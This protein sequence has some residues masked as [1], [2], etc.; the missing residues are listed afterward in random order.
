MYRE[1]FRVIQPCTA[2]LVFHLQHDFPLAL[3]LSTYTRIT[4]ADVSCSPAVSVQTLPQGIIISPNGALFVPPRQSVTP[5]GRSAVSP[6][7]EAFF[8]VLLADWNPADTQAS[9]V[10]LLMIEENQF[11]VL[12]QDVF[13]FRKVWTAVNADYLRCPCCVGFCSNYDLNVGCTSRVVV[14]VLNVDS[15]VVKLNYRAAQHNADYSFS[16]DPKNEFCLLPTTEMCRISLASPSLYSSITSL[17]RGRI[18]PRPVCHAMHTIPGEQSAEAKPSTF[19]ITVFPDGSLRYR[20]MHI[21]DRS[22]WTA[23]VSG[24]SFVSPTIR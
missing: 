10:V 7:T 9:S 23:G 16:D 21:G 13:L 4:L 3:R 15:K 19:S 17:N 11:S 14:R 6:S 8:P 1:A 2:A 24:N 12:Y 18:F 20:Y 22:A 5:G